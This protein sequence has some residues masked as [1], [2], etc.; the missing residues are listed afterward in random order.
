MAFKDDSGNPT[1]P[2][3]FAQ[4]L[5]LTH[6]AS[7]NYQIYD[8]YAADGLTERERKLLLDHME[9]QFNRVVKLFGHSG[10]KMD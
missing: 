9:K 6:L 3:H 5:L 1:T 8:G 7:A 2:K 4:D 10:W